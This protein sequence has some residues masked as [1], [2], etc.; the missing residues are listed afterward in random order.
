MAGSPDRKTG[1]HGAADAA[2]P[3]DAIPLPT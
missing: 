1:G 3:K 2:G